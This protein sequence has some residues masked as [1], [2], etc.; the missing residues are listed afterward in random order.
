MNKARTEYAHS[1]TYEP[2]GTEMNQVQN[3]L[4]LQKDTLI[5]VLSCEH[6]FTSSHVILVA[7]PSAT[8]EDTHSP[9]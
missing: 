4:L 5:F 7:Q 2:L 6:K 1:R 8:S 3:A 9:I